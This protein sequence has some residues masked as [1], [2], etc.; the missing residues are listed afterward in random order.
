MVD[1]TVD[2]LIVG[3]GLIGA[4][5]MLALRSSGYS[6]LLVEA[7]AIT[8]TIHSDFDARTLAL[9]PA[10]V[11]ILRTLDVW[12]DLMSVATPIDMIHVSEQSKFGVVR[13]TGSV[14][15]PLG[16]VVEIQHI[17]RVLHRM[18][19]AAQILAP[20]NIVAADVDKG[21]VTVHDGIHEFKIKAQLIVAADGA[22]SFMRSCCNL[23]ADVTT[24]KQH[25]LIANIGLARPHQQHAYERFTKHGPLALLPMTEQRSALVWSLPCDHAKEFA[26]DNSDN[27]LHR[28]QAAF[29]YRLG[30]FTHVGKRIVYP[31]EN[32]MMRTITAW[33]VVFVGNAAHTLHPV[34]GQGFNLGLRDVAMLA[35]C[36]VRHGLG[37]DMLTIYRDLRRH[38]E[39]AITHL[40][41]GLLSSFLHKSRALSLARS[42][43]FVAL[44]NVSIL[45]NLLSR[46]A[47]GFGGIAAD[48]V[49][50]IHLR[51]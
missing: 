1:R 44:D 25:A 14:T 6:T 31:L 33:P 39:R 21:V 41:N 36:I 43:G 29:G 37:P 17:N 20:A 28:L 27:F 11:A 12:Q 19:S 2:I 24:Y 7:K 22:H 16:Q 15:H 47:S 26:N 50:G 35:Q 8:N 18:L 30:R 4:T 3:G 10:S 32:V 42:M 5:L 45:K 51:G 49:C 40:T 34:A 46:Y 23:Y 13:L 38:D 9:A 48:L